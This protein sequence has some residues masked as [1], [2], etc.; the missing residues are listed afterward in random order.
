MQFVAAGA[1]LNSVEVLEA[2]LDSLRSPTRPESS[3]VRSLCIGGRY[4]ICGAVVLYDPQ[5]SMLD[6]QSNQQTNCLLSS[7]PLGIVHA[8]CSISSPRVPPPHPPA[9]VKM[10]P[11]RTAFEMFRVGAESLIA[12]CE[13]PSWLVPIT[14]RTP[15]QDVHARLHAS[16]GHLEPAQLAGQALLE[17]ALHARAGI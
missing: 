6:F 11:V 14:G 16:A 4:Q 9:S 17:A 15:R 7:R 1:V 8:S 12:V 5:G 10:K 13:T 2:L 3:V